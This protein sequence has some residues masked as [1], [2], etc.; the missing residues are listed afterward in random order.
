MAESDTG[1]EGAASTA[2]ALAGKY[3][4]FEMGE[5]IYGLAILKV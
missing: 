1:A 3:L 5:E 2:E 4:T